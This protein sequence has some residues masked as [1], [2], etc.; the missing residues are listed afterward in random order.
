MTRT[1]RLGA[2]AALGLLALA[3]AADA[4]YRAERQ[5]PLPDG[6]YRYEYAEAQQG[7]ASVK[8]PV[9]RGPYGDEVLVPN[10]GWQ[11]CELNCRYTLQKY[12]LNRWGRMHKDAVE[13]AP[14]NWTWSWGW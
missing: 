5:R 3:P 14:G 8:A 1:S 6:V 13:V 12:H 7:T 11:K 10:W 9:R 4:Q 2:L